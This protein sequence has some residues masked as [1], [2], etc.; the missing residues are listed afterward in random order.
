MMIYVLTISQYINHF[1]PLMHNCADL[2]IE[3]K[4]EEERRQ[5]RKRCRRKMR[6]KGSKEEEWEVRADEGMGKREG[7]R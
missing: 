1:K 7:T 4:K 2:E 6:R 3:E 5:R